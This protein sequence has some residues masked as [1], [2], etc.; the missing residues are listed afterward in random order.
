MLTIHHIVYRATI[1]I[2]EDTAFRELGDCA[3]TMTEFLSAFKDKEVDIYC[4]GKDWF[5]GTIEN[6]ADGIVTLGAP[7]GIVHISTE[8]ILSVSPRPAA[9]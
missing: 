5:Y 3:M 4:G 8:K 2:S 9:S 7:E 6:L 1:F